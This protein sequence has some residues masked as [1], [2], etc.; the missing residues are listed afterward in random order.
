[1]STLA[2][3]RKA[4]E[5]EVRTAVDDDTPNGHFLATAKVLGI[6]STYLLAGDEG[7][8]DGA[9]VGRVEWPAAGRQGLDSPFGYRG[10]GLK[11]GQLLGA[12]KGSANAFQAMVA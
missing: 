3:I 6:T 12:W 7:N 8:P 5:S 4:A 10:A 1:V 9:I 11:G 2:D